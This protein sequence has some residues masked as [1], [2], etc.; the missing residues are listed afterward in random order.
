MSKA[1]KSK[2]RSSALTGWRRV[3]AT[4]SSRRPPIWSAAISSRVSAST[5]FTSAAARFI[6]TTGAGARRSRSTISPLL[7]P[8]PAL[9]VRGACDR[10]RST[11]TAPSKLPSPQV[12]IPRASPSDLASAWPRAMVRASFTVS[13]APRTGAW[14]L[15]AC[16]SSLRRPA[17]ARAMPRAA[18]GRWYSRQR[19]RRHSTRSISSPSKLHPEIQR[20]AV[21]SRPVRPF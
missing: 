4:G 9:A 2:I 16:V 5:G 13:T 10:C 21:R 19:S 12:Y 17:M 15:A 14:P 11:R 3:K 1:W 8:R 18:S 7:W 20:R 6:S